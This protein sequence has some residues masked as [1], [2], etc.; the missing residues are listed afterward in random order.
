MQ[1]LNFSASYFVENADDIDINSVIVKVMHNKTGEV[2]VTWNAPSNPNG[3]IVKYHIMY[4]KIQKDVSISMSM[5]KE[6]NIFYNIHIMYF[7]RQQ[8]YHKF[9]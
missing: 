6:G 5:V 2:V 4:K 7:L 8:E 9:I 1:S 3:V